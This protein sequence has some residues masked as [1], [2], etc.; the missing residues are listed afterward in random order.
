MCSIFI[1]TSISLCL[2]PFPLSHNFFPQSI[3]KL[4]T[5]VLTVINLQVN[6]KNPTEGL[7][8]YVRL[9][10][11]MKMRMEVRLPLISL[12]GTMVTH[13]FNISARC[14]RSHGRRTHLAAH[15]CHNGR[16][17]WASNTPA[18][19]CTAIFPTTEGSRGGRSSSSG[20]ETAEA[21]TGPGRSRQGTVGQGGA[22][23]GDGG[24][25]RRCT[26]RCGTG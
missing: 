25:G 13:T 26:G 12:L 5:Y 16:S 4:T 22:D 9:C 8:A 18:L 11:E 2:Y 17:N 3:E 21:E 20:D 19:A 24:C 23:T 7:Q 1:S 14:T 15:T 6:P 10:E